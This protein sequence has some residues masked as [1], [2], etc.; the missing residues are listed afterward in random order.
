MTSFSIFRQHWKIKKTNLSWVLNTF[1][2]IMENGAFALLE[3]MLH[4]P[5]Y[6][7]IHDFKGI[8]MSYYGVMGELRKR[9]TNWYKPGRCSPK[10]IYILESEIQRPIIANFSSYPILKKQCIVSKTLKNNLFREMKL[11][12][13]S[14]ERCLHWYQRI[15]SISSRETPSKC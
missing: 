4:F 14:L 12:T 8:K 3:Q 6:S 13:A 9:G 5:Q 10:E 11:D 7:Q 1:E 15:L 2:N